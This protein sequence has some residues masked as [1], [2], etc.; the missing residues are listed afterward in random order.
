MFGGLW[1]SRAVCIKLGQQQGMTA[2]AASTKLKLHIA[3]LIQVF[4]H[5]H[6]CDEL[7]LF[8]LKDVRIT[9]RCPYEFA[10]GR[11]H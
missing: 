7:L 6:C 1:K 4:L 3:C 5:C 9:S 10:F 2:D 8:G 11:S